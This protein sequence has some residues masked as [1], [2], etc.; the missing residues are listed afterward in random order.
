[1]YKN[2]KKRSSKLVDK[3]TN[4][5]EWIFSVSMLT[6]GWDAKNVFQ[7]IPWEDRSFN[8]KLLISQVLGRGLRIPLE[9]V[10]NVPQIIIFNHISWSNN[11]KELFDELIESD[12]RISSDV[13][14]YNSEKELE[15]KKYNFTIRN[16]NYNKT[17]TEI[18]KSAKGRTTNF[19]SLL[20]KRF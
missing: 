16:I 2:I 9:Y 1:M 7:I 4:K 14:T 12:I 10:G 3:N 8:S 17:E 6:E 13:I 5:I 15:R 19:S 11:I 18:K 20:K